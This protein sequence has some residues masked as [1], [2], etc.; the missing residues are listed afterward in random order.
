MSIPGGTYASAIGVIEKTVGIDN[1][2]DTS[3]DV[4]DEEKRLSEERQSKY[5]K[6]MNKKINTPDYRANPD[7][8]DGVSQ[9]K[10]KGAGGYCSVG[11]IIQYIC[12]VLISVMMLPDLKMVQ[13]ITLE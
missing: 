4:E 3:V 7:I 13:N 12:L 5:E 8:L 10:N 9:E 1:D 2:R 6:E 11:S